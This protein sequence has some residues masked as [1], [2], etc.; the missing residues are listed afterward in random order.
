[1]RKNLVLLRLLFI[2]CSLFFCPLK[3][4]AKTEGFTI[5]DG[6]LV[7][8]DAKHKEEE[9]KVIIPN[10][11]KEIGDGA[12][13]FANMEEV[14]IPNSVKVIG[15]CAF[16]DCRDLKTVYMGNS[17]H[18]IK[19][20]AFENCYKLKS[21]Q[22]PDSLVE[23]DEFAFRYCKALESISLP[24]SVTWLHRGVFY[25]C[26][27]LKTV[28]VSND[29]QWVHRGGYE[30]V[31][32]YLDPFYDCSSITFYAK[33]NDYIKDFAKRYGFSFQKPKLNKTSLTLKRGKT[34]QLS[35]PQKPDS[36]WASSNQKIAS[37]SQSGK[38]TARARGS[39]T[40][41]VTVS[42]SVYTCKVK[43]Q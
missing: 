8:Y 34:Y 36:E 16:V 22:L 6:V 3:A 37:V 23:I 39:A 33:E 1:M 10:N 41:K 29:L 25:G 27:K 17:V 14:I 11:V 7:S 4:S 30:N 38:V 20:N 18:T 43:V 5:K 42:G 40:V 35:L 28:Y 9:K 12:F 24:K 31:M 26:K 21:I 2:L 19:E 15:V 13:S 32:D